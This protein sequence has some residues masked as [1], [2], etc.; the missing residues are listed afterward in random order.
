L[1]GKEIFF[2]PNPALL[3]V[4]DCLDTRASV[5]N[6]MVLLTGREPANIILRLLDGI[7]LLLYIF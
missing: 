3:Y 4:F 1:L 2:N 7:N 5:K 6:L